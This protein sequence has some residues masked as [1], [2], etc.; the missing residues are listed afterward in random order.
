M[1]K[2]NSFWNAFM[3]R[4][5]SLFLVIAMLIT[6]VTLPEIDWQKGEATTMAGALEPVAPVFSWVPTNRDYN[7]KSTNITTSFVDHEDDEQRYL[8]V[9]NT[10]GTGVNLK[11]D[12]ADISGDVGKATS[13][14][15]GIS[16][17][18]GDVTLPSVDVNV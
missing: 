2:K 1:E 9:K 8:S 3:R 17:K 11:N 13:S 14:T 16:Q 18:S 10:T 12:Y 15:T 4:G 7:V 5:A 6:S